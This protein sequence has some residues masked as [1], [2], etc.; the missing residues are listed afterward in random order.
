MNLMTKGSQY[1]FFVG[2]MLLSSFLWAQ[3]GESLLREQHLRMLSYAYAEMQSRQSLMQEPLIDVV[4]HLHIDSDMQGRIEMVRISHLNTVNQEERLA[5]FYYNLRTPEMIYSQS[6]HQILPAHFQ[7]EMGPIL[8]V[9]HQADQIH[10]VWYTEAQE[11]IVLQ[12]L[13]EVP[14]M[15]IVTNDTYQFIQAG[16]NHTWSYLF[17]DTQERTLSKVFKNIL[18]LNP[19]TRQIIFTPDQELLY[20][21]TL[22]AEDKSAILLNQEDFNLKLSL[23]NRIRHIEWQHVSDDQQWGHLIIHYITSLGVPSKAFY[24]TVSG[25]RIYF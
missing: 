8:V 4:A 14:I 3:Q 9:I 10:I 7:L 24:H 19:L 15:T 23:Q 6:S 13:Q 18:S 2:I 5:L 22:F 17:F 25:E 20:I 1:I 11:F 21:A 16:K 12:D